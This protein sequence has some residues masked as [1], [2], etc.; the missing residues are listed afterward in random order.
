MTAELESDARQP[1]GQARPAGDAA[2]DTLRRATESA[3]CQAKWAAQDMAAAERRRRTAQAEADEL[4][5]ALV[6][7]GGGDWHEG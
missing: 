4:R 1:D 7:L 5:R 6:K 3:E 2:L